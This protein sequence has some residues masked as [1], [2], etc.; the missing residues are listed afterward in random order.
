MNRSY[1]GRDN[2]Y[3]DTT[4]RDESRDR[5][6][7][8]TTTS[9]PSIKR[10][11]TSQ[12][13][14]SQ[15]SSTKIVANSQ[16][17]SRPAN[18]EPKIDVLKLSMEAM[19]AE[20]D[21]AINNSS[22]EQDLKEFRLRC[23]SI[24]DICNQ[25]L[26]AKNTNDTKQLNSLRVKGCLH[27]LALKTLNRWDKY[28]CR[29]AKDKL[30][31]AKQKVDC[32]HLQ[33]QNMLYE[34]MHL[35]REA[36]TCL[37][38][39]S[40]DEDI[41]LIEL[42]EFKTVADEDL[43]EKSTNPHSTHLARLE[44]ELRQRKQLEVQL[45]K[46]EEVKNQCSQEIVVKRETL[47]KLQPMLKSIVEATQP[48][49]SE[50]NLPLQVSDVTHAMAQYLSR[51]LYVLYVQLISY[52]HA[53]RSKFS[54][55]INGTI[56]DVKTFELNTKAEEEEENEEQEDEEVSTRR[57]KKSRHRKSISHS[58]KTSLLNKLIACHPLTVELKFTSNESTL[59]CVFSFVLRLEII[60][61]KVIV[62]QK[63]S[64]NHFEVLNQ[65]LL[66]NLLTT[67]DDSHYS[68][69]PS[70][71]HTIKAY[72]VQEFSSLVD[73][74]GF[75]YKWCQQIS[76]L[77]FISSNAKNI[78]NSV[79][80]NSMD[81]TIKAISRR[82]ESRLALQKQLCN[83]DTNYIDLPN[84]ITLKSCPQAVS[85]IKEFK[86]ITS[87]YFYSLCQIND[88]IVMDSLDVDNS[89]IYLATV[90][91]G[92]TSLKAL[93]LLPLDYPT[94]PPFFHL[95]IGNQ[96]H[97]NNKTSL[98]DLEQLINCW[99]PQNCQKSYQSLLLSFQIYRL[100]LGFDMFVENSQSITADIEGPKEFSSK[101]MTSKYM[102]G[103]DHCIAY[104]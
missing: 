43:L 92:S 14:G 76:G 40:K 48:L 5:R 59:K 69:N 53:T 100:R 55:K 18:N 15:S 85:N 47:D 81:Q 54:V 71:D 60:S 13:S 32:F 45:K 28:R 77:D 83:L 61:L 7:S 91:R 12:N 33:L 68:P 93:I 35:Q 102:T 38:F 50:L 104:Y 64:I 27:F 22:A 86:E 49:Y 24:R 39:H 23:N 41:D 57:S 74:L 79:S 36:N 97:D 66:T 88:S 87:E 11:K 58:N 75:S 103:R 21:E 44:W 101:L 1:D 67:K 98:R 99:C 10:M 37:S 20:E 95:S 2:R 90:E 65:S 3:R 72:G 52:K 16:K 82:F 17:E 34:V 56:D 8:S 30:Q 9:S 6:Q 25:I 73:Q 31:V 29:D 89:F 46:A 4:R 62:E 80:V 51:P 78:S 63:E 42:Q 84:E 19:K 94:N 26:E 70:N 96:S